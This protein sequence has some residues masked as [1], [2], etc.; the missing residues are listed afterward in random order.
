MASHVTNE[1]IATQ[2]EQIAHLLELRGA[3]P[4]RVRS[5]REAARQ[6]RV[7]KEPVA[8]TLASQ[9][10]EA[11]EQIPGIGSSLA[12]MIVEIVHS[13]RAS[14]LSRLQSE[15]DPTKL[16]EE[17]PGIGEELAQRIVEHLDVTSLEEL[18]QAAHDGRLVHVP[19]FGEK[20]VENVRLSLAGILSGAAQRHARDVEKSDLGGDSDEPSIGLLLGID[21]DYRERAA[22]GDLRTIAPKRFNPEGKAWLPVMDA[23]REGWHFTAL[24]SNTARAHDLDKTHDWVV[25]YFKRDDNEHQVTVV[26]ETH[27]SL[28]GK[29]VVRGREAECRR[30]YEE[31]TGHA[32]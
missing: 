22:A 23:D 28:E 12:A 31:R 25:V 11:L 24:F 21:R 26:T 20:R 9:G 32:N 14:L 15:T 19:G 18:E 2:F 3:N 7:Q 8:N 1:Q 4:F 6:V 30:Y 16:F 27:G 29:R 17:V 5:Y 10:K 13:G